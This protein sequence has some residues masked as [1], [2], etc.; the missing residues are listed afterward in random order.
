M[1]CLGNSHERFLMAMAV[2]GEWLCCRFASP[3]RPRTAQTSGDLLPK[4]HPKWR[5]VALAESSNNNLQ[6]SVG[7]D[8]GDHA[9]LYRDRDFGRPRSICWHLLHGTHTRS[10]NRRVKLYYRLL[11]L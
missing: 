10:I 9:R 4:Y 5:Q 8:G 2:F 7:S 11:G 3:A 1:C 6:Y